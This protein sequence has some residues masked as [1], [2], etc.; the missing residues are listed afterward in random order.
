MN[1]FPSV[2]DRSP[3]SPAMKKAVGTMC[4]C[5]GVDLRNEWARDRE[6]GVVHGPA[7]IS[8]ASDREVRAW[9]SVLLDRHMRV[10]DGS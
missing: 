7:D 9:L 1:T 2:D 10:H 8:A 5:L 6:D 3:P 4:K